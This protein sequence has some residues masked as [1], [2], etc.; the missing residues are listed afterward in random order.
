MVSIV[1]PVTSDQHSCCPTGGPAH[2]SYACWCYARKWGQR[3]HRPSCPASVASVLFVKFTYMRS[4]SYT[5]L[6]LLLCTIPRWQQ[7]MAL[8][9]RSLGTCSFFCC[10]YSGTCPL[11]LIPESPWELCPVF[12]A[13]GISPQNRSAS[14]PRSIDPFCRKWELHTPILYFYI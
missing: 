11:C 8:S 3:A 7:R 9:P 2:S 14:S 12:W 13:T 1:S 5:S 6:P 4:C 10:D